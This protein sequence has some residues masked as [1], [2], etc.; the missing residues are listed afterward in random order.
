MTRFRTLT[1]FAAKQLYRARHPFSRERSER[2]SAPA[3]TIQLLLLALLLSLAGAAAEDRILP[4]LVAPHFATINVYL[5]PHGKPL[6]AY[7]FELVAKNANVTLVGLEGGEHPAFATPPYYDTKANL[8]KRIVVAAFN[9]GRDLPN[10]RTRV[11]RL[12]VRVEAGTPQYTAT[13]QTA[14]TTDA[15]TLPVTIDVEEGAKP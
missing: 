1:S 7:Q 6:A 12:M 2:L 15:A 8:E 14:A 3:R 9:P 10:A 13:L 11:A 5:D 4:R